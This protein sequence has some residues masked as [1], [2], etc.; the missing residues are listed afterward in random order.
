MRNQIPLPLRRTYLL[1][2]LNMCFLTLKQQIKFQ[3]QISLTKHALLRTK[4][5]INCRGLA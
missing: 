3:N 1:N 5:I 2:A 4:I